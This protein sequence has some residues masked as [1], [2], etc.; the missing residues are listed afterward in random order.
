M[1]FLIK[2]LFY[3][4][5]IIIY[6]GNKG[7]LCKSILES[8]ERGG[9][10]FVEPDSTYCLMNQTFHWFNSTDKIPLRQVERMKQM[11]SECPFIPGYGNCT[12][13]LEQMSYLPVSNDSLLKPPFQL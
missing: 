7:I 6:S 11:H 9:V 2:Q 1:D 10:T 8:T 13:E 3:S 12:C 4:N 5:Y